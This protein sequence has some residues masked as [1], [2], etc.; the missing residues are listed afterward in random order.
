MMALLEIRYYKVFLLF[1][2][3]GVAFSQSEEVLFDDLSG[4]V[5]ALILRIDRLNSITNPKRISS[6]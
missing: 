3:S 1:V 4:R 6:T 2:C 5:D